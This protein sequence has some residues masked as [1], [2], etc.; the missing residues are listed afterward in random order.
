MAT[1]PWIGTTEGGVGCS[2]ACS[3]GG[4]TRAS[5]RASCPL[6]TNRKNIGGWGEAAPRL[7]TIDYSDV[8]GVEK[9]LARLHD[10]GFAVRAAIAE[11]V[12]GE[13]A[14]G[15]PMSGEFHSALREASSDLNASL[16]IDSVQ[17]C[18]RRIK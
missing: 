18:I 16:I 5:S 13:G 17:A 15:L 8:D 3:D 12:R 4:T 1:G 10:E 7:E 6:T 9:T 11:P 2:C 14:P